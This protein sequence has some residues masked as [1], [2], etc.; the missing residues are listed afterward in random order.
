MIGN[1]TMTRP[2]LMNVVCLAGRFMVDLIELHLQVLKRVFCN[3][4]DIVNWGY[5]I[6]E[7]MMENRLPILIMT[8]WVI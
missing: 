5:F 8:I 4:K 2:L 6:R 3:V 1:L 7:K